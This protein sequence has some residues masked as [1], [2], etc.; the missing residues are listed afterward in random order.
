MRYSLVIYS[1]IK[2]LCILH[3]V[4]CIKLSSTVTRSRQL[5]WGVCIWGAL[6]GMHHKYLIVQ[7]VF[8]L[9]LAIRA[10][11]T[12]KEVFSKSLKCR[13][14]GRIW[15]RA[16]GWWRGHY[17]VESSVLVA[18]FHNGTILDSPLSLGCR[19]INMKSSLCSSYFTRN[20]DLCVFFC[21]AS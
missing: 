21:L 5:I 9:Y 8:V 17:K 7:I 19:R 20:R 14:V 3:A 18:S 16:E 6:L 2:N 11:N 1:Q 13:A 4:L 12:I 10:L 15:Y